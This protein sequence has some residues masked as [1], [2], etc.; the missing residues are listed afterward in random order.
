[1][2]FYLRIITF[3]TKWRVSITCRINATLQQPVMSSIW[4][5]CEILSWV[6]CRGRKPSGHWSNACYCLLFCFM[7]TCSTEFQHGVSNC[8]SKCTGNIF[9][10]TWFKNKEMQ[11]NCLLPKNS[12]IRKARSKA[13]VC[14][15]LPA[16]IVGSNPAVGMDVFLLCVSCVAR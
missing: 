10:H 14:G 15:R 5:P 13:L 4:R 8:T 9:I 12:V 7:V 3:R 6:W 2:Y 1:M 16:G 11:R